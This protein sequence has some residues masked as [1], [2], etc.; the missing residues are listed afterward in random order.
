MAF[1]SLIWI[2]I[3]VW[4]L[5]LMFRRRPDQRRPNEWYAEDGQDNPVPT[6]D[7]PEWQLE[8]VILDTVIDP[9][10][11]AYVSEG[12][13]VSRRVDGSVKYFCSED[14]AK[15]FEERRKKAI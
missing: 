2:A 8:A 4:S 9:V 6:A 13:S 10:C 11:G 14:C 1:G 5:Y 3:A 12:N 15:S 7:S